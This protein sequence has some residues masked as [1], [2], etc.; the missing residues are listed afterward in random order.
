LQPSESEY[1]D[2][3]L[4][5]FFETSP[6]SQDPDCGS[7]CAA[8]FSAAVDYLANF[9]LYNLGLPSLM[10]AN[11]SELPN[12]NEF[13]L[14]ARAFLEM[15]HE[16]PRWASAS[17]DGSPNVGWLNT[18]IQIGGNLQ[19]MIGNANSVSSAGK[20]SGNTTLF[21][22]VVNK[23]SSAVN[24]MDT[25][26][27]DEIPGFL[28]QYNNPQINN[29]IN[30]STSIGPDWPT[31][32]GGPNQVTEYIPSALW[33]D[34]QLPYCSNP[35]SS[36]GLI[37]PP[38]L[39]DVAPILTV[40]E[41]L[42]GTATGCVELLIGSEI[43]TINSSTG[44][45]GVSYLIP[46]VQASVTFGGT[47][48]LVYDKYIYI[49]VGASG[50]NGQSL[51]F[52]APG[53]NVLNPSAEGCMPILN[54]TPSN[55]PAGATYSPSA[56]TQLLAGSGYLACQSLVS[57]PQMFLG[58][59]E[60]GDIAYF[61]T[62]NDDTA[63]PVKALESLLNPIFAAAQQ[64]V[65]TQIAA[66]FTSNVPVADA[67]NQLT[68]AKLLKQ[69][70]AS[71]G[72]PESITN[73]DALHGA[74]YGSKAIED[75]VSVQNDWAKIAS[76]PVTNVTDEKFGDE[77]A[78]L[79]ARAAK[80]KSRYESDLGNVTKS[81]ISES[82]SELDTVIE[83]LTAWESLVEGGSLS[84]CDFSISSPST[85]L[86][87]SA[88]SSTFKVQELNKCNWIASSGS[89]WVSIP[90]EKGTGNGVVK[91]SVSANP[92]TSPRAATIVV[93]D[94]LFQILQQGTTK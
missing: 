62:A 41:L 40:G 91:F 49:Y 21:N 86:G 60:S 84:A 13:E 29:L 9:P 37:P 10:P 6:N 69:A 83:D 48:Y 19:T 76:K 59:T 45:S 72:L 67:A 85:T 80:L 71:Y 66:G 54:W 4:Y 87:P 64:Y 24:Q 23:Y 38:N 1:Q 50:P 88:A 26:I 47:A 68:G 30:K 7:G 36:P 31:V 70:Y 65:Y 22:A 61:G 42:G 28:T 92:G 90:S 33:W 57:D 94:Q 52:F 15:A 2:S 14:G 5:D 77:T 63:A 93:G 58:P 43:G 55:L 79:S 12:P 17:G 11:V 44:V 74:L 8:P 27:I 46:D 75:G 18:M 73:D 16:W 32:W 82:M 81:K 35:S 25:V 34:A 78:A 3:E 89:S 56:V 53:A 51:T 20:L 39:L